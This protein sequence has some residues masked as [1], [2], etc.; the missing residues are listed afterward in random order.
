M[1]SRSA[2]YLGAFFNLRFQRRFT[3]GVA[4]ASRSPFPDLREKPTEEKK[5]S[6]TLRIPGPR[7]GFVLMSVC[8]DGGCSHSSHPFRWCHRAARRRE[9]AARPILQ[10][11]FLLLTEASQRST[12]PRAWWT[13]QTRVALIA[14]SHPHR[15]NHVSGKRERW[16]KPDKDRMEV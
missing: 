16:L 12:S 1:N 9:T 10:H 5:K 14:R 8:M 6:S 4:A 11:L 13:R 3:R 7:S 2:G 15:E